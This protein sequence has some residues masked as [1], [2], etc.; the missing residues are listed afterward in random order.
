VK[1]KQAFNNNVA[2]V[3]DND[4]NEIV[5]MGK[6]VGFKKKKDEDI[7]ESLIDKMYSLNNPELNQLSN[8]LSDIPADYIYITNK[9]IE[10]GE[11][12]LQKEFSDVFLITLV[13][14]INFA[15]ERTAQG[16]VIQS[17]LH[18]EVKNLYQKEYQ[19]GQ[20]AIALIKRHTNIALPEYEATAI[21]LHFVNA[22]FLQ[23]DIQETFKITEIMNKILEIIS[24]HYQVKLEENSI[25][26]S[27]LLTHLRYFI[28][29]QMN[30]EGNANDDAVSFYSLIKE[31]YLG[32]YNCVKK[33]EK[34]LHIE[35][36]WVC[37]DEELAYLTLHIQRMT[38][39]KNE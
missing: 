36:G 34:Y 14:H 22:Q 1:F 4:N 39:R 33:I 3:L 23:E 13:D 29:R 18:W 19:I 32:A 38:T 27:R 21:A 24:Y 37:S 25:N 8:I 10:I 6:G 2:L 30:G 26:Y 16:I 12:I 20:E 28:L 5:V 35:H 15:L 11:R 31:R 17:P 7:D 9:I